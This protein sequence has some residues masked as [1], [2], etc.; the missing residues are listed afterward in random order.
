[1]AAESMPLHIFDEPLHAAILIGFGA[2]FGSIATLITFV[3]SHKETV[4]SW[5]RYNPWFVLFKGRA[6]TKEEGD[7]FL[8][9]PFWTLYGGFG[10]LGQFVGA[11]IV[12][13]GIAGLITSLAKKL[14]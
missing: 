8:P 7:A 3:A 6:M 11:L 10:R 2:V 9:A 1:M 4:T 5:N 12:L 13:L 14:M